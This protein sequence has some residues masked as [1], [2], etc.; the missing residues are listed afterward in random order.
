[1][2]ER[3]TTWSTIAI[4]KQ[5]QCV[6]DNDLEDGDDSNDDDYDGDDDNGDDHLAG[7]RVEG[8]DRGR[9]SLFPPSGFSDNH[10]L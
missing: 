7:T 9:R 6:N 2:G 10:H 5:Q 4:L 3:R 8:E 1:M